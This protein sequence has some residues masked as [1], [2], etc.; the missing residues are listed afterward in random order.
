[1]EDAAVVPTALH[2]SHAVCTRDHRYRRR[3]E[4]YCLERKDEYAH[5]IFL[6][7]FKLGCVLF[8]CVCNPMYTK[9]E[10]IYSAA[11]VPKRL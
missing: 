3:S 4:R 8:C 6:K 9:C 1:M 10:L 11:F 2:C 5:I 7:R